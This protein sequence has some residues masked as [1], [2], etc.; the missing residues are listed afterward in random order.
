MEEHLPR[1][2]RV[3]GSAPASGTTS[4]IGT[5][6]AAAVILSAHGHDKGRSRAARVRE[7]EG[8]STNVAG[9]TPGSATCPRTIM[10]S[11]PVYGTGG[12]GPIPAGGTTPRWP[13]WE[14]TSLVRTRAGFNPRARHE[15]HRPPAT[16]ERGT[17]VPSMGLTGR[18]ATSNWRGR[19]GADPGHPCLGGI[20][21]G[22]PGSRDRTFQPRE[23][24]VPYMRRSLPGVGTVNLLR[25][26]QE[27]PWAGLIS[28][29][30]PLQVRPPL[31]MKT[32]PGAPAWP[33]G[34]LSR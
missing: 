1:K 29:R 19:H 2:Q 3:A 31:P 5:K 15:P 14:G 34:V 30:R 25:G 12:A 4:G 22:H 7:D 10:D 28:Q 33:F 26:T 16:V 8:A 20:R 23:R 27:S 11:G 24:G 9:S 32:P 13:T 6:C 18:P 17:A 21:G